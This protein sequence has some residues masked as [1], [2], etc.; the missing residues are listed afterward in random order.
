MYVQLL[1]KLRCPH[2]H[3][4]NPLVATTA[5]TFDSNCNAAVP[6]MD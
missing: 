5:V 2:D 4:D 1:D 6:N 3:E